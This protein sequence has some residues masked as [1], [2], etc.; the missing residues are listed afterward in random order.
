MAND[1]ELSEILDLLFGDETLQEPPAPLVVKQTID[2]DGLDPDPHVVHVE[3][4]YEVFANK[5]M[6]MIEAEIRTSSQDPDKADK[7]LC[8]GCVNGLL[9][10][11]IT[12]AIQRSNMSYARVERIYRVFGREMARKQRS[13]DRI[14][15][16]G[17]GAKLLT[18]SKEG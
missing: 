10:N 16:A 12:I 1:I 13:A 17:H 15:N 11:L 8:G 5:V 4:D 2:P 7:L 9:L 6:D 3:G 14:V 18:T